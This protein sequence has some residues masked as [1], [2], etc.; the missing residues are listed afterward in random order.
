MTSFDA[1]EVSRRGFLAASAAGLMSQA[2]AAAD[3]PAPGKG[4]ID[5]HSHVWEA[6]DKTWPLAPGLTPAALKP[7]SFTPKELLDL[8][9]PEGV[10]RV[11]LIQHTIYHRVDNRYIVDVIRKHPGTF[12][13]V[14]V[15]DERS[16][17]P[18]EQMLKLKAAGVRGFRIVPRDWQAK[19]DRRLDPDEWLGSDGMNEMWKAAGSNGLAMCPLI[20]PKYLGAVGAACGRHPDT[21]C[22]ID[23]FAR[24]G[25][26]GEFRK[27]DV[28]TL[29][30]LAAHKK[31]RVKISA[32]YA[33]GKKAPPYTELVPL[34][35]R[36]MDTFGP[37]RLMW[38]SDSPYQVVG[39]HTYKA[40]I[41]LI[42]NLDGLSAGDR[43]RL[44]RGTAE[45]TFFG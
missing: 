16:P 18:G 13:G 25:A 22:V 38:G 45:E 15:V 1:C 39:P 17:R 2:V 42:K 43:D 12:S 24:V 19:V 23:H 40:S 5:C 35:R 41:D 6:D 21:A 27:A 34:I 37:Q 11:V 31:V 8:A 32:Y 7:Q 3:A 4:F 28:D 14:A 44:L 26:D 20:D 33:L 36:L 10:D 9:R 29:C 30:A